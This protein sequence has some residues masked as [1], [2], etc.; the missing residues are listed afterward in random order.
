METKENC[1]ILLKNGKTQ[2]VKCYK[3]FQKELERELAVHEDVD[4]KSRT[5]ITDI[6]TGF[7]LRQFNKEIKKVTETDINETLI[8]FIKHYTIEGIKDKFKE[9]DNRDKE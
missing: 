9:I 7:G 1:K 5:S 8:E 6:K 3:F 2:K 4:N